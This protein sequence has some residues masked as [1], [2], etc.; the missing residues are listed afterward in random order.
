MLQSLC[1]LQITAEKALLKMGGGLCFKE[2]LLSWGSVTLDERMREN[3]WL[4]RAR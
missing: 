2:A 4:L 1:S 3:C